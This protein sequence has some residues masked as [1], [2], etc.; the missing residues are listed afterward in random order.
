MTSSST[1]PISIVHIA[2]GDLW[3]GAEVQMFTLVK[4]LKDL[5]RVSVSV[6]LMNHGELE[7]R[8]REQGVA[9]T[10]FDESRLSSPGI[11][12]G[13]IK[14]LK[15]TRPDV[16][17]THRLKENV[18]GSIA[19]M[20]AGRI[21]SIRTVHGAPEH[22]FGS[23]QLHKRLLRQI[24]RIVGRHLQNRIIAVSEDLADLLRKHYPHSQVYV[25]NN[26]IEVTKKD[27]IHLEY[28]NV[29]NNENEGIKI[30]IAGRLVPIKRMDI[31][32]QTARYLKDHYHDTPA[33][34]HIYGDGPLKPELESLGNRLDT[35]NYV[36][37]RGH[38]ENMPAELSQLDL[39]LL[40]SDHEGLPMI[41]LEAMSYRVPVI[42]HAVGGIPE[43][44]DDGRCGIL[45][46]SEDPAEYADAIHV[47]ASSPEL[48]SAIADRAYERVKQKYSAN[49][50]AIAYLS[51]YHAVC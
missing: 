49:N 30:G 12:K 7:N 51:H 27:H 46:K 37:F 29:G 48:R 24:D 23:L 20:F 45:I 39:L 6:I 21:P 4:A 28:G 33:S 42:A 50:N 38:V 19:A 41:L 32:I 34:F 3:A 25:I 11:L 14:L 47:L 31:F 9:V 26:G 8:L 36:H 43:L 16:I 10:V 15:E 35:D 13:I 2:S 18:L 22:S 40:T 17:H 1:T 44:L 5:H